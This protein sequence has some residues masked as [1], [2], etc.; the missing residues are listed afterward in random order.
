[1][2]IQFVNAGNIS[3]DGCVEISRDVRMRIAVCL[4][5]CSGAGS[6]NPTMRL[7]ATPHPLHALF[8]EIIDHSW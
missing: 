4:A 5:H 1:M 8:T 3:T 2:G 7:P 6:P